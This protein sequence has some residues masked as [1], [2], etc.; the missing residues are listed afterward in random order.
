MWGL[1]SLQC[2]NTTREDS[3]EMAVSV[4]SLTT[5]TYV[6]KEFVAIKTVEKDTLKN[7]NIIQETVTVSGKKSAYINTK[8][9]KVKSK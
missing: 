5:T 7:V 6:K 9:L 3:A 8:N 2:A 1:K 4:C